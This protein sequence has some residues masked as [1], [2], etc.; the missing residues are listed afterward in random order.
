M[1]QITFKWSN[2]IFTG[3]IISQSK[4]NILGLKTV[5]KTITPLEQEFTIFGKVAVGNCGPF[6]VLNLS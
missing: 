5:I 6:T 2:I 4:S 1:A 3:N